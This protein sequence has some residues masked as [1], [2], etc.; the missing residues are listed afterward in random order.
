MKKLLSIPILLL[1]VA[2]CTSK[3]KKAADEPVNK[4][5]DVKA[6]YEKNLQ[7]IKASIAA[8]EK[9]DLTTFA[10]SIAEGAKWHSPAYG[11]TVTT[12]A[13]CLE[14][15]KFF[16]DNW[17]NLKLVNPSFLPGLDSATHEMDGSVRYYGTWEGV[18][19]SGVATSVA[20]YGTY[21]FNKD[22]KVTDAAEFFDV[23]GLMNAVQ[24][25]AK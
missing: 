1:L 21:D 10:S 24:P 6:L 22:G 8:F 20:F 11:D 13:H 5:S 7:T 25:K 2:A 9:E 3:E 17:D 19:K 15:L 23:G 4:D 16:T 12:A 18:H 14:S